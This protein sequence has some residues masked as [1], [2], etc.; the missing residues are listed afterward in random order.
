MSTTAVVVV[1][2]RPTWQQ[3]MLRIQDPVKSLAF[4]RDTL[5][6]TL[7]DTLD[8]PQYKFSLYFLTTLPES[9]TYSLTPGTQAAHDYLWSMEGV[10][11]ELTHNHDSTVVY[12][13]GNQEKDGFGHIAVSVTDVYQTSADLE[14]AGVEFKKRPDEGRMKGL[15]FCYDPDRYWVEIVKRDKDFPLT[16]MNFS[17]TMLRVKDPIKSLAFYQA[18]GMQLLKERHFDDFSL[19]FLASSNVDVS[20]GASDQFQ[21]VL[22]LTHNHGTEQDESFRHYNGNEEGRPGFGHIGFLV[23]DVYTACDALRPFG[24][25][26][27]KEP[28]GGSMKGLAFAYD[29][30]GYSVEIIKR[31]GIDFGDV[32]KNGLRKGRSLSANS[33]IGKYIMP[34]LQST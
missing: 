7:I 15:A 9:E 6:M 2:G 12:H 22:E 11:L 24:Y 4:Y 23:D 29:P 21:P 33:S 10:A 25:G 1:P 8:F 14:A 26:F 31:G 19:Y 28:D 5:G 20:I 34:G 13:P 3:T 17:Q 18:L 30:D 16:K 32:Q 27:R